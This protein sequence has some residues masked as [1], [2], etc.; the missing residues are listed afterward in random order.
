MTSRLDID[1]AV[2]VALGADLTKGPGAWAWVDATRFARPDDGPVQISQGRNEGY[3]A[4]PPAK[5][6]LLV[7]NDGR[8]VERNPNGNWYGQIHRNVPLRFLADTGNWVTAAADTFT[9]R[10]VTSGWGTAETGQAWSFTGVGGTVQV[11]D[12]AVASGV[13]THSVPTTSAWRGTFVKPRG[14]GADQDVTCQVTC[15]VPTGGALEPA[16]IYLRVTDINTSYLLCRVQVTTAAAVQVLI[17]NVGTTLVSATTV[18]GLT[19]SAGTPLKVRAQCYGTTIRI[20]VWQG[21]NEPTY[22]HATVVDPSPR[23]QPGFVGI[24]SGVASG[25]TNTKPVVFSYDNVVVSEPP[26]RLDGFIDELPVSWD[27]T[28]TDSTVSIS[29]SGILRRMLQGNTPVRSAI[30]RTLTSKSL[31]QPVQYWPMEDPSAATVFASALPD[32]PAMSFTDVSPGSY[33]GIVGSAA[34]PTFGGAGSVAGAIPAFTGNTQW[35]VRCVFMQTAAAGLDIQILQWA[36]NASLVWQLVITPAGA[37]KLRAYDPSAVEVIA[38]GGFA[39]SSF[40]GKP[41]YLVVNAVQNGANIDWTLGLL[42]IGAGLYYTING[43]VN[44]QTVGQPVTMVGNVPSG[45]MLG[46]IAVYASTSGGPVITGPFNG[47]RGNTAT[48]RISGVCSDA[49][50]QAS[51]KDDST[52]KVTTLGPQPSTTVLGILQDAANAD[53]GILH[54]DGFGLNYLARYERYNRTVD[55]TID[56]EAK[57]LADLRAVDD[58]QASRNDVTVQRTGGSS[59][60]SVNATHVALY[61]TYDEVVT[62]NLQYDGDTVLQAQWRQGLG[63]VD[64]IRYPVIVLNFAATPWLLPAWKQCRVGSRIQIVNPPPELPPDLIDLEI[65]GW[66]ETIDPG[67]DSWTVTINCTSALPFQVWTVEGAGNTGRLS[68]AAGTALVSGVSATATSLSV[69]TPSGSALWATGAQ[70]VDIEIGGE[71]MTVTNITGASSP[72]TFTVTRSVNGVVKPQLAGATVGLYRP[73]GLAL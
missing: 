35:A 37:I 10:T 52:G 26:S 25:N 11:S 22:W 14:L 66:S 70:S 60:R 43:T 7:A 21:A 59:S 71:Q 4:V 13:A 67:E 31:P 20:R 51:V 34:L 33:S 29:A 72:Q 68:P 61:G 15:P 44:S 40:Y 28:A 27:P 32:G 69:S 73:S 39:F 56:F 45:G 42:D 57:E 17:F 53:G 9:G 46:H 23:D 8:W 2:E 62:L 54:E 30:Y 6:T 49:G 36:T 12:V 65:Q 5:G 19:H 3:N 38:S 16:N 63:T 55:L 47:W 48:A 1:G 50:I 24:R 58:D 64:D 18:P 41:V